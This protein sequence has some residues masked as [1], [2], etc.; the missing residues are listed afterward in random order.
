MKGKMRKEIYIVIRDR[1]GNFAEAVNKAIENGYTPIGG[2]S[3]DTIG[4]GYTYFNQ[5][6]IRNDYSK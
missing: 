6:M 2:V 5:A 4:G 3:V 1:I